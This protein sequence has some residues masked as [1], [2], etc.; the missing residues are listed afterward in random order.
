[1]FDAILSFG[2]NLGGREWNVI[3]GAGLLSGIEGVEVVLLSSLYE[4]EPEG[5]GFSGDFVNAVAAVRTR[6]SP[7]SLLGACQRVELRSGRVRSPGRR[8]RTLD[9]DI[10]FFGELEIDTKRLKVPHT[11]CRQRAF[12]LK[13]LHEILPEILLPPDAAPVSEVLESLDGIDKVRKISAR[14]II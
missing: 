7:E 9:I 8:D 13:P 3:R 2:S 5:E 11:R 1:M 14:A 12:V 6:L 10:I 4:S